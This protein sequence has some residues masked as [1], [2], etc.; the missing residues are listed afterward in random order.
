MQY[1]QLGA[2][3][4]GAESDVSYNVREVS[5]THVTL[6][7]KSPATCDCKL[8]TQHNLSVVDHAWTA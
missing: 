3:C 6:Y 7:D 8:N 5:G 2:M 4:P 1:S